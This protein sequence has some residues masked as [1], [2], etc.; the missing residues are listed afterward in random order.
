MVCVLAWHLDSTCAGHWISGGEHC[1]V[2]DPSVPVSKNCYLY[3]GG[4]QRPEITGAG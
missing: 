3:I 4:T 1:F 2:Q